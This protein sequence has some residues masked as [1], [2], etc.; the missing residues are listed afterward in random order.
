[1]GDSEGRALQPPAIRT[2]GMLH[3]GHWILPGG[4]PTDTKTMQTPSSLSG[5]FLCLVRVI[6]TH[7]RMPPLAAR[8]LF[9]HATAQGGGLGLC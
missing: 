4:R 1:M 3:E 5:S 2:L 6:R 8:W 9:T 7:L